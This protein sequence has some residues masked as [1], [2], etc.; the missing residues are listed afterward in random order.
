M[1]HISYIKFPRCIVLQIQKYW[2]YTQVTRIDLLWRN[3]TILRCTKWLNLFLR[4]SQT[5]LSCRLL[6]S[7]W[8]STWSQDRKSG[9]V[10]THWDSTSIPMYFFL[11]HLSIT[12]LGYS[13]V[14]G[15]KM[16]ITLWCTKILF[17]QLVKRPTGAFFETFIITELSSFYQHGYDRYGAICKPLLY[18]S[19]QWHK[20]CVGGWCSLPLLPY[21]HGS[22]FSPS[23]YLNCPSV[24]LMSSDI[25]TAL[26]LLLSACSDM[27]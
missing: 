26:C 3:T 14:I 17:P 19:H 24:A 20:K 25:F 13:T 16:I 12:D 7:S 4:G 5:V 9:L 15:L 21:L 27:S 18:R 22:G 8:S 23:S 10:L 2:F 11:R 1:T 6:E